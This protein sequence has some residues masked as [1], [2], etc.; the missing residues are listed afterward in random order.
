M[1]AVSLYFYEIMSL[2]QHG[3]GVLEESGLDI[4]HLTVLGNGIKLSSQD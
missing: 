4:L 3:D 1:T 2:L